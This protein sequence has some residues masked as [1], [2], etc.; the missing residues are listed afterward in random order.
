MKKLLDL[1]LGCDTLISHLK[2][3]SLKDEKLKTDD[4]YQKSVKALKE[5]FKIFKSEVY[6]IEGIIDLRY[7]EN[8]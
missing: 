7:Y 6:K 3:K 1:R 8:F 5:E 2:E 4:L